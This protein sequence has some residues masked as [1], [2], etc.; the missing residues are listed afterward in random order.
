MG[1]DWLLELANMVDID[2]LRC[3]QRM[4]DNLRQK[5]TRRSL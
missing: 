4:F 3:A 5:V 1:Y 2:V